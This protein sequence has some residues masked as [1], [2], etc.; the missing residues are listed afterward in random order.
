MKMTRI[1]PWKQMITTRDS[2]QR[3]CK[4]D[5][6]FATSGQINKAN[7]KTSGQK[8]RLYYSDQLLNDGT[9]P[10]FRLDSISNTRK[11]SLY[12]HGDYGKRT[13]G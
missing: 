12:F 4:V 9:A 11:K 10:M 5:M 3:S 6:R 1:H 7:S 8:N 13:L 2:N